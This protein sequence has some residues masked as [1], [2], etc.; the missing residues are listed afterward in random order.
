MPGIEAAGELDAQRA[1]I[2]ARLALSFVLDDVD[3]AGRQKKLAAIVGAIDGQTKPLDAAAVEAVREGARRT[4]PAVASHALRLAGASREGAS[5]LVQAI[6]WLEGR[7]AVHPADVLAVE[8]LP[9][10]DGLAPAEAIRRALD[11]ASRTR[12]LAEG[13]S[14]ALAADAARMEH[15][16]DADGRLLYL[17]AL[18][19]ATTERHERAT[20]TRRDGKPLFGRPHDMASEIPGEAFTEEELWHA[21]FC[22]VPHG[23]TRLRE[24][25]VA[26]RS[27]GML[28][29]LRSAIE[30][31]AAPEA[32][33]ARSRLRDLTEVLAYGDRACDE[34]AALPAF[35]AHTPLFVDPAAAADVADLV[36]GTVARLGATIAELRE[37]IGVLASAV[38]ASN[39]SE[40]QELAPPDLRD[41]DDDGLRPETWARLF[42]LTG[43]GLAA[44]VRA[45][46]RIG[47]ALAG[48]LAPAADE[49]DWPPAGLRTPVLDALASAP[50]LDECRRDPAEARAAI[51]E[52]LDVLLSAERTWRRAHAALEALSH[53]RPR[54]DAPSENEQADAATEAARLADELVARSIAENARARFGTAV[55]DPSRVALADAVLAPSLGATRSPRARMVVALSDALYEAL[56][57][58]PHERLA[59]VVLGSPTLDAWLPLVWLAAVRVAQHAGRS[60]FVGH[61]ETRKM[62]DPVLRMKYAV[63]D[64]PA[65]RVAPDRDERQKIVGW[66][67]PSALDA[68]EVS[69]ADVL[70]LASSIDAAR[71]AAAPHGRDLTARSIR[72]FG[73][74][75][76]LP[77]PDVVDLTA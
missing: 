41:L 28:T 59:L 66:N 17:D 62:A 3:L 53:A 72:L 7:S 18:G 51:R 14:N 29:T 63:R 33:V 50:L 61:G 35:G 1:R 76:N 56:E 60:L 67:L 74:G 42:T 39:V 70:L 73:V 49:L 52:V 4:V 20:A 13:V 65:I 9:S 44:R 30:R 48:G 47:E 32:A 54:I 16:T 75:P 5:R 45:A 64:T 38:A 22:R 15:A 24:W 11:R 71:E 34:L 10:R 25:T 31:P 19:R 37:R 27:T 68:A 40:Q 43:G 36:R 26:A 2:R 21:H 8:V 55:M 23:E 6:A 77:V 46:Q 57:T 69:H 12:W 58:S